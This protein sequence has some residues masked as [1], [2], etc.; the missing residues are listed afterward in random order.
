MWVGEWN[1]QIQLWDYFRRKRCKHLWYIAPEND[2]GMGSSDPSKSS[3]PLKTVG[4]SLGCFWEGKWRC[5]MQIWGVIWRDSW[6]ETSCFFFLDRDEKCRKT[7][8]GW[9]FAQA[10]KADTNAIL[11]V[12]EENRLEV[13][14]LCGLRD[15][16]LATKS[17]WRPGFL[18]LSHMGLS[19]TVCIAL[20]MAISVGQWFYEPLHGVFPSSSAV[21]AGPTHGRQDQETSTEEDQEDHEASAEDQEDHEGS[22]GSA[23]KEDE[24]TDDHQEQGPQWDGNRKVCRWWPLAIWCDSG[25]CHCW[26]TRCRG[27][28]ASCK[29][30]TVEST[31]L[32]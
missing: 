9:F 14:S 5:G 4:F 17:V 7:S 2:Y 21:K 27:G 31:S 8:R 16:N 23:V 19:E 13:I 24:E 6:G 1:L 11:L 20:F 29:S 3:F 12:H 22:E 25:T 15:A 32:I 30:D 26:S 18:W 28:S 10:N